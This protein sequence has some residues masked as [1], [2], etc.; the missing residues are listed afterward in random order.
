M[1][2]A[3]QAGIAAV[4]EPP[5]VL[6]NVDADISFEPDYFERLLGEVR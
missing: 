6:V 5:D 3:L 2:R 1:V 4:A